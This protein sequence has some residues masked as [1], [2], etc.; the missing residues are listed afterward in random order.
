M[1]A[2]YGTPR[3]CQDTFPEESDRRTKPGRSEA[4][5]IGFGEPVA[6]TVASRGRAVRAILPRFRRRDVVLSIRSFGGHRILPLGAMGITGGGRCLS[7]SGPSAPAVVR[8]GG[9]G[10]VLA[11]VVA[12]GV[13]P[14]GVVDDAVHDR[15]GVDSR[16][17]AL[18]PVL[19]RVLG[20]EDGR[21]GVV[22]ALEQF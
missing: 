1:T 12:A 11:H 8:S 9:H 6:S 5:H 10:G 21:G 15:I 18:V 22:A 14:D 17:E 3:V 20:A 19:L 13:D 7:R 4:A 16:A 2:A